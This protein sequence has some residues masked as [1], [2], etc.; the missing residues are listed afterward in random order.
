MSA[1]CYDG[2]YEEEEDLKVDDGSTLKRDEMSE[3]SAEMSSTRPCI[4]RVE[5]KQAREG[6]FSE[7]FI[8]IPLRLS[9]PFKGFAI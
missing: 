2:R 1:D 8:I 4:W 9:S 5:T 3:C 6:N 7:L